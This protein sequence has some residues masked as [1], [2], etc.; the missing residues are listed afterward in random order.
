MAVAQ[1]SITAPAPE[2]TESASALAGLREAGEGDIGAPNLA[3][4]AQ[5]ERLAEFTAESPEPYVERYSP[6]V[7]LAILIGAMTI[8]WVA[9]WLAIRAF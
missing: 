3:L 2:Q 1:R 5:R 6:R 8:P 9:I 7:R 4:E